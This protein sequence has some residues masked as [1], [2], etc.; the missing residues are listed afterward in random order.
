V[1]LNL[2]EVTDLLGEGG[3][4]QVHKVRHRGWNM[5]LAVK[6][7][8]AAMIERAG[9][10]ENFVSECETWVN[11]GLHPHIVSCYYVRTLGGIPR[12]FAEYVEG[13]SLS[14]WIRSGKLYEGGQPQ[15]LERILDISIQFA[16][17]LRYAHEQGLVHQDVKPLNVMMTPD[18]IAKVTDFGLAKARAMAG[19]SPSGGHPGHTVVVAGAG[20]YTPEYAS[21]EQVAGHP[22]SRRTDVWSWGVSVLEMFT[23]GVTWKSGLAALEV[24]ED[25][26]E[27][28]TDDVGLRPMPGSVVELLMRCFQKEEA[29]RPHD[30]QEVANELQALYQEAVGEPYYREEPKAAEALADSLN[31]RGVSLLDLGRREEAEAIWEQALAA[32]PRHLDATYN[33][34]LSRWRAAQMTDEALVNSLRDVGVVGGV[35]AW[36]VA[37]AVA[38]VLLESDDCEGALKELEALKEGEEEHE[39]VRSLVA[40]ARER[41][42]GSRRCVRTFQGHTKEGHTGQVTSVCLTT[43]VQ[44][45]WKSDS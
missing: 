9:G 45:S 1:I 8:R 39:E 13:G 31:N 6:S 2:Y 44:D 19:E 43:A 40:R 28:G 23:G 30:M 16:W 11:L 4:G 5:D 36:R 18:G 7:P 21:P 24:L 3:M 10:V 14:D 12:V 33:L 38:A 20:L 17:G 29:A 34:G 42:P 15:A 27:N 22:L 41:L 26:L 37:V 32:Q 25:Y 35:E